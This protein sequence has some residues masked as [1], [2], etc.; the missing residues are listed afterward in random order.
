MIAGIGIPTLVIL[1]VMMG[2]AARVGFDDVFPFVNIDFAWP[3]LFTA[4]TPTGGDMGAHVLLPQYLRDNLLPSGRIFGWTNDW[5]AGYPV[6]Y[7]YFP[8]PALFTVLLDVFLPFG[9]AFKITTIMGLLAMPGSVYFLV[10]SM[11][12]ARPVAAIATTAGAMYVFMESFSIFGG[13]VKSTLAGEFSF[14]WGFALS[15][16]YLGIVIRDTRLGRKLSV[17]AGVFLALTTLT[18]VVATLVVVVVSL[19]LLLRHGGRRVVG[20]SWMLGFA[21]SAFWAIPFFLRFRAG[22]T[23]NM[24]WSPVS[25]LLGDS[26]SPGIV[27]TPL[28]NEFIPIAVLGLIGLIWTMLRRDDVVVLVTMTVLPVFAYWVL[29]LDTTTFT[30]VYNARLLPYWYLGLY[31]F[32]G[33]GIGLGVVAVARWMPR[34][35]ENLAVGAAL[36][37]GTL[38]TVVGVGVHDVPGW[39]RWNYTGL[40]GKADFAEYESLI[41]EVSALP[42][43]RVMWEYSIEHNKYGTPM[44]LMMIPY[45][46]DEHPSME[47]LYFESSLTTPFHFLNQAEVSQSPSQPVRFITY[48]SLDMARAEAHLALYDVSY[49]VSY[50]ETGAMAA[51][52]QGW[53]SLAT[54]APFEIFALP[55][56]ELIDIATLVPSVWDG[57]GAFF[58]ATLDYY[59]DVDGLDRWVVANGPDEWRRIDDITQR[60]ARPVA[61]DGVVS[62]I[63]L[64]DHRISFTTTAVGVPHLVKVSY[65]PNWQAQGAE[66]PYRAAPSLMVVVPTE[67]DVVLEF[68]RS[69][70]E[71]IGMVLTFAALVGMG[72]HALR[73]RR[74]NDVNLVGTT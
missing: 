57:E 26:A 34:R 51:T 31:I 37:I 71:Y 39:V 58:D 15:L 27:A 55:D 22:L 67:E 7:F 10:R 72:T 13:N 43:G 56:T 11:G 8:V 19:P 6:L 33:I 21:I 64:E 63:K 60:G 68:S 12:F 46:S 70:D 52:A 62:D 1:A 59:D 38:L 65:F 24:G 2:F 29:Q 9:V 32:A 25:G 53:E 42:G 61:G 74:Q 47:G 66:G 48:R 41:N 14:S 4:S 69:G 17:W 30:I 50:T 20:W 23:T 44:A 40:E 45:F 28:P 54:T 35:S 18:H 3:A 73:R 49:Y 16:I 36:A 5:Y